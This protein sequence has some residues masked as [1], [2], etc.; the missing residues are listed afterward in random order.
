MAVAEW[1]RMLAIAADTRGCRFMQTRWFQRQNS[2]MNVQWQ[3]LASSAVIRCWLMSPVNHSRPGSVDKRLTAAVAAAGWQLYDTRET[4]RIVSSFGAGG[5]VFD[6]QMLVQFQIPRLATRHFLS[7]FPKI[8]RKFTH[9]LFVIIN[10]TDSLSTKGRQT[11]RIRQNK[12]FLVGRVVIMALSSEHFWSS[13]SSCCRPVSV[14]FA[15]RQSSWP[16]TE[17]QHV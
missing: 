15:V 6:D 5:G 4:T 16:S 3:R 14:E 7:F 2:W 13:V 17:S 12:T 8:S 1:E 9:S 11:D 10:L